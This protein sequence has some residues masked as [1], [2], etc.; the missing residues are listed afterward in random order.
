MVLLMSA[1][2]FT[3]LLY[4]LKNLHGRDTVLVQAVSNDKKSIITSL[5]MAVGICLAFVNPWI[6]ITIFGLTAAMW[7]VPNKKIEKLL[8]NESN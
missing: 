4:V 1:I 3:I 7:L 5:L 2:A 8:Q 6:A